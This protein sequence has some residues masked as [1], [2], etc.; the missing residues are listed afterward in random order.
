MRRLSMTLM[1]VAVF[2]SVASTP[3]QAAFSWNWVDH[4]SGPG[5]FY[6][7]VFDWRLVCLTE[8]KPVK[9]TTVAGIIGSACSY[10]KGEQRRASI[11]LNFGFLHAKGDARFADGTEIK[12]TTL[13]PTF[14]W[15]IW[16]P[17]EAGVGAG[18][19]WFSANTFPSVSRVMLEPIRVDIRPLRLK[20]SQHDWWAEVLVFRFGWV[21]IPGGF[22]PNDFRAAPGTARRIPSEAVRTWGLFIDGEPIVRKIR[23][24]W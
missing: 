6:G 7:P 5:P 12:L 9:I 14:S 17:F 13:E 23:D 21:V 2:L 24:Q 8:K 4:L 1:I 15:H 11:D 20:E 10:E 3:A 16:G 22:E 18:V 19:Y